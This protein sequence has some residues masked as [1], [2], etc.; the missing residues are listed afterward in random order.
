MT[1]QQEPE[2]RITESELKEYARLKAHEN[3]ADFARLSKVHELSEKYESEIRSRGTIQHNPVPEEPKNEK[4]RLELYNELIAS[5]LSDAEARGT[6]WPELNIVPTISPNDEKVSTC[7]TCQAEMAAFCSDCDRVSNKASNIRQHDAT[8]TTKV[9]E[10]ALDE[11]IQWASQYR[12]KKFTA[13]ML[14]EHVASLRSEVK[15]P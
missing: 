7:Q 12:D 5:G 15:K 8:I 4:E 13:G 2:Y 1:A 9:R 10:E 11:V 6:A 14:G 3:S